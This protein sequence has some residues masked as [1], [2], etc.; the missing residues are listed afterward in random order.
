MYQVINKTLLGGLIRRFTVN[1]SRLLYKVVEE[2]TAKNVERIESRTTSDISR[3]SQEHRIPKLNGEE[4]KPTNPFR[5]LI[6]SR[7]F[8]ALNTIQGMRTTPF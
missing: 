2:T 4:R 8:V 1:S 5:L 7:D 3:H 6:T